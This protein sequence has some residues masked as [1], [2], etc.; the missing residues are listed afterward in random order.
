LPPRFHVYIGRNNFYHG[1]LQEWVQI[2]NTREV[3]VYALSYS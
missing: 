2:L 1:R 3:I